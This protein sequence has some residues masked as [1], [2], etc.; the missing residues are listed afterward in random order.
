MSEIRGSFFYPGALELNKARINHL[1][2]LGFDF[3]NKSVLETGCGGI[4]D[5]TD[6]LVKK[7]AKVTLNDY[8][9]DNIKHLLQTKKLDLE[10]NCNDLNKPWASKEQ[11]DIIVSYG[12]LY[13]LKEPE[14]AIKSFSE[15][16]NEFTILSTVTNGQNDE[17]INVLWEDTTPEQAS[18]G[19]GC[20]PGR[21][22]VY[23]TFKKYFP[24]VYMLKTQPNHQEYPLQFPSNISN[25]R[26]IFIGS[27]IPIDH[28]MFVNDFVNSYTV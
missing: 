26:N 12:T 25:K 1:D 5:I 22:F 20:R 6:F 17:S 8:R 24:Y 16:C 2:R 9:E 23:N 28:P 19:Y 14:V 3:K 15:H 18:D 27:H 13:H 10:Y 21:L 4:G 7:G 11:Y